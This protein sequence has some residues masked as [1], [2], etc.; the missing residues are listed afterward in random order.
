MKAL[1]SRFVHF[2]PP[3]AGLRSAIVVL[4]GW[5]IDSIHLKNLIPHGCTLVA[6]LLA[7]M[8]ILGSLY[9]EQYLYGVGQYTPM[10]GGYM[11]RRLLPGVFLILPAI[12]W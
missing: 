9:R 8:A 11:L 7:F 12:G 10:A 2:L 1:R 3:V 5:A 6:M 4:I